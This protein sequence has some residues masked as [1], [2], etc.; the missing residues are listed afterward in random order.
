MSVATTKPNLFIVGQPKSGTSALFSF[1]RQHPKINACSA[2][3]PSYFCTDIRS[4]HFHLSKTPRELGN[5]LDLYPQRTCDYAMEGSTSYLYSAT[6]AQE[7]YAF[8]PASKIIILLREPAKFLFTYHK[9]L[10]RNSCVFEEVDSFEDALALEP[11]RKK[12][13][14]LPAGVFDEKFLFYSE[15]LRYVEHISRY[16]RLFP[17]EQ[18]QVIVYDDF[19]DDNA[20]VMNQVWRFLELEPPSELKLAEVNRQVAVRNRRVK[21]FLDKHLFGFKAWLKHGTAKPLFKILRRLYRSV[22]FSGELSETLNP[23]TEK[24]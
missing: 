19:R 17:K 24:N 3:E 6:A 1:L 5:Y 13:E 10:L 14:A 2:K 11:R 21:Q 9:Q 8:N 15:R 7:I 16:A 20:A 22:I 18:I 23:E 12:G 4:Q